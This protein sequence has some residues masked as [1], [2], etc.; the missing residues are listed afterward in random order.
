MNLNNR[1]DCGTDL[2]TAIPPS[3]L[4]SELRAL[5]ATIKPQRSPGRIT[6][7]ILSERASL[8]ILG[9]SADAVGGARPEGL[10]AVSAGAPEV[11]NL[12]I[13]EQK[14]RG[15]E[16]ASTYGEFTS[17][18]GVRFSKRVGRYGRA[19]QR[20]LSLADW[21]QRQDAVGLASPVQVE[22]L[23]KLRTCG[24]YLEFRQYLSLPDL[25]IKLHAA[26]FCQQPKL[27]D[28]C[29]IRRSVKLTRAYVP[30]LTTI[31]A[32]GELVPYFVT[33]TA[34]NGED[35]AERY[36]HV[37]RALRALMKRGWEAQRGRVASC[38]WSVIAGAVFAYEFK[39]GSGTRGGLWH[40]HAHGIILVRGGL[41]WPEADAVLMAWCEQTG[42]SDR[43][44]QDVR[45]LRCLGSAGSEAF[46]EEQLLEGYGSDLVEVFK[47]PLK[48]SVLEPED[49][50]EAFC[51]VQ[52]RHL[53]R[54]FGC[55]RGVKVPRNLAD[56]PLNVK[57][58]P[59]LRLLLKY[60]TELASYQTAER[61]L[62]DSST[63]PGYEDSKNG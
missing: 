39:R 25:P 59:Y 40:P 10:P 15:D 8:A 54:P 56:E 26:Q 29:A 4:Q 50:W 51:A 36:G 28:F 34:R 3:A 24:S 47:Y 1:M 37:D 38:A 16:S 53:I 42:D 58:L 17:P 14:D 31:T 7:P 63:R 55:L 45:P 46:T 12:S 61:I 52:R 13:L 21:V 20:A 30:K 27:C 62:V 9:A 2:A 18:D 49:R 5:R 23:S 19:R 35:L 11:P 43:R 44:A 22:R 60:S 48:F 6:P 41:E 32:G 33:L 57:D